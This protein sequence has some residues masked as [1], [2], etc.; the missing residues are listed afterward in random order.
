MITYKDYCRLNERR[1]KSRQIREDWGKTSPIP[2][3]VYKE[4]DPLNNFEW[5]DLGLPSDTLWAGENATN[6]SDDSP[7]WSYEDIMSSSYKDNTPTIEQ[8]RELVNNCEQRWDDEKKGLLLIS[9]VNGERIFL[10]AEGWRTSG[11]KKVIDA[12]YRGMYRT[13]SLWAKGSILTVDLL[14]YP[15][16]VNPCDDDIPDIG[17]S[18]RLVRP[19]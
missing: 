1:S 4:V 8:M 15:G 13:S 9:R 2:K 5:V 18:L 11:G 17:E 14:F 12:G 7:Y 10:P 3:E 6:P 19:K 16:V